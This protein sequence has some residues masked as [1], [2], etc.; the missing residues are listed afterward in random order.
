MR[1]HLW[2]VVVYVVVY[3]HDSLLLSWWNEKL[4]LMCTILVLFKKSNFENPASRN[5][6][7]CGITIHVKCHQYNE[8]YFSILCKNCYLIMLWNNRYFSSSKLNFIVTKSFYSI[9]KSISHL[10]HYDINYCTHYPNTL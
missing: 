4:L 7:I 10:N 6:I 2:D 3:D 5:E 9:D 1:I 8:Y